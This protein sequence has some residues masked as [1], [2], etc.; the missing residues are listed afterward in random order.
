MHHI[1]ALPF[2]WCWIWSAKPMS[3]NKSSRKGRA[4]QHWDKM[5]LWFST[6]C[7]ANN[8]FLT[9]EGT[10]IK[11]GNKIVEETLEAFLLPLPLPILLSLLYPSHIHPGSWIWLAICNLWILCSWH[12]CH[13]WDCSWVC[14]SIRMNQSHSESFVCMSRL[15]C[16]S[17]LWNVLARASMPLYLLGAWQML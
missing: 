14:W 13:F 8:L 16:D 9:L 7:V 2:I 15:C 1:I 12:S 10:V 4:Q 6:N 3:W 5:H 11:T 17:N